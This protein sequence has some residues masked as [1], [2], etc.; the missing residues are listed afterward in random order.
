M[1]RNEH[2]EHLED[3]VLNQGVV[4]ARHAINFLQSLRNALVGRA[5]EEINTTVK[6][7]GSPAIFVGKDVD[8]YPFQFEIIN[9]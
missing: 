2:M 7:D 8:G 1:T 3:L 9:F 4:G 6:W 5:K